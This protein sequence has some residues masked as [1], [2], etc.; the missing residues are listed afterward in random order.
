MKKILIITIIF[1]CLLP[2]HAI[3]AQAALAKQLA[4]RILLQVE[5]YGR[6]WYVDPLS[7]QRYY[8]QDGNEAYG[9]MRSKGL[10]ITDADL[11]KIPTKANQRGDK[12]LVNRLKGRILLQ[13]QQHGEAWYLNPTDGLRYY[14]ADGPAAY[15]LMKKFGLG[16]KNTH[17]AE[18]SMNDSQV[19]QDTTL[20]DVAYVAFDGQNFIGG[21]NADQILPL[22]SL[23][24]LMTALVFFDTQPD[25]NK[26]ITITP[27]EIN[28]PASLAGDDPTSEVALSA[29]D[30][31]TTFDLWVAM[32]VSS[33][34][35]ATI[36]LADNSG[37]SR[38]EFIQKMNAKAYELGLTKTKFFDP[39][40][41]D[42]HNVT[43]AKEMAKIAYAAF[44]NQKV[45]EAD[46][47]KDYTITAVNAAAES[48]DIKVLNRNYSLEKFNPE[49][50]KTGFL[51]EAQRTVTLKKNGNIIV[52]LHALSMKQRN[53]I[54]Q[55]LI[56]L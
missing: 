41:L 11:S 54:I 33:S 25:W 51:V 46:Q 18:I 42:A 37:L 44:S 29:G 20:N 39:T 50:S 12:K 48:K 23:S 26:T 4:G 52:V 13:V 9:L 47:Y 53:D 36:A 14:L 43:T 56:G 27:A 3:Q 34:N 32:L 40:G 21:Y 49:A 19:V 38:I 30:T 35:Q 5:S 8:L 15:E 22:A 10:G 31:M 17:L 24:K 7:L 16:I 2:W 6:A 1:S 55:K 28:Y 45:L